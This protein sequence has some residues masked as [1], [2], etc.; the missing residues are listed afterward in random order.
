M[1]GQTAAVPRLSWAEVR[2]RRLERHR[3]A[4]PPREARPADVVRAMGGVAHAQVMSAVELSIGLRT[5]GVTR[6][7]IRHT[8]WAERSLVKTFGPRGT[9][10]L[11]PTRDLPMWVGALSA[12]RT[13]SRRTCG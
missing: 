2:A 8:L 12:A 5:T 9:V 4:T 1:A 13:P 10:H 11:L 7:D 3:L 6:A